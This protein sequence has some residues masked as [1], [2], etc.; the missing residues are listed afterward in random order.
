MGSLRAGTNDLHAARNVTVRAMTASSRPF[1][2]HKPSAHAS[3]GADLSRALLLLIASL[4]KTTATMALV[5]VNLG[6]GTH[7]ARL[8]LLRV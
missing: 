6:K 8:L 7:R 3:A 1:L 5:L 2:C 4:T